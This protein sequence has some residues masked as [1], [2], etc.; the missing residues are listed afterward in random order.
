VGDPC[1]Q[2]CGLGHYRMRGEYSVLPE[3]EWG[4]WLQSELALL[5]RP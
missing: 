2:L 3:A 4:R 1:S 5:A